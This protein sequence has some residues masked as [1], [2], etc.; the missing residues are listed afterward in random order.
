LSKEPIDLPSSPSCGQAKERI[1]TTLKLVTD[2]SHEINN[3]LTIIIGRSE[4]SMQAAKDDHLL[5]AYQDE[6]C[7][8]AQR[9]A[10]MTRKLLAI[11]DLVKDVA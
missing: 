2:Y 8:A 3:Q 9:V 4:Q 7:H 1:K 6:I 11:K 10:D 5:H